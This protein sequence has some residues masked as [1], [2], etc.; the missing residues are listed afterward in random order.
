MDEIEI[1]DNEDAAGD[2]DL[3]ELNMARKGA[4]D[5]AAACSGAARRLRADADEIARLSARVKN[6]ESLARLVVDG[7]LRET[8]H[9]R[10][11][12]RRGFRALLE[13]CDGGR[14]DG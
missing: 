3:A 7:Q 8:E 10:G 9:E 11:I 2:M 1:P 12:Y 4:Y 5:W 6:F 13:A 14:D